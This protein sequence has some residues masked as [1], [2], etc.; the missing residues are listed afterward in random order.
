MPAVP[1]LVGTYTKRGSSGIYAASL[2]GGAEPAWQGPALAAEAANPSYLAAGGGRV[3]AVNEDAAGGLTRYQCRAGDAAQV[4]LEAAA[5]APSGGEDPCYVAVSPDASA[6]A[7][8]NYTSGSW[9]LYSADG[10]SCEKRATVQ[11]SGSGPVADR[12]AGPHAH[13]SVWSN[14]GRHLYVVDLGADTIIVYPGDVRAPDVGSG[15][16][17]MKTRPGAGPRHIVFHPSQPFAYVVTELSNAV[18]VAKREGATGVLTLVAEVGTLP[19]GFG[20]SSFCGH[21]ALSEDAR[22][23]YVSNRGHDSIATFSVSASGDSVQLLGI[24]PCGGSHPRFFLLL[25]D[26]RMLLVAN[27]LSDSIACFKLDSD[28]LPVRT[29]EA[30]SVPSP[31]CIVRIDV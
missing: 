4:R 23:L 31:T 3:F 2:G 24:T 12:Q 21:I 26:V 13:C 30:L 10:A 8:A 18:I 28:G 19:G 20:G 6:V 27:T 15:V 17:A 9:S 1:L 7:V 14:D 29:G 25:D 22:R 5:Q 11:L 16:V